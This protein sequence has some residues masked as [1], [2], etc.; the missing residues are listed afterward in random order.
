MSGSQIQITFPQPGTWD[1][2]T[3]TAVYP[4]EGGFIQSRPQKPEDI[5][6]AQAQAMASVIK[7]LVCLDAPWQARQV[8]ARLD[9][10][11]SNASATGEN[12]PV[13][14]MEA[15][16][17]D[18]EAANIEGGLRMFTSSNYADFILTDSAAIEFFKYF[19]QTQNHD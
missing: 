8:W 2:F 10:V 7:A 3:L 19:T 11:L 9:Q 16:I 18:V 13:E 6:A 1:K 15:V 17:L 5:P 4:D 12:G 14:T